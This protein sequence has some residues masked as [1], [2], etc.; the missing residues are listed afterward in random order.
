MAYVHCHK[1]HWS[2][3]D[4]WSL[5]GYNPVRWFLKYEFA[6]YIRP[7]IVSFDPVCSIGRVFSWYVIWLSLRKWAR[8]LTKQRWWTYKAWRKDVERGNGG[9]PKCGNH[10]CID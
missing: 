3:D 8:R 4:F 5:G 9:C 7:R 1:C 6:A 2:Q 10:L